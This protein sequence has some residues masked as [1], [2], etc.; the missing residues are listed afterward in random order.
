MSTA[1]SRHQ[2]DSQRLDE[3]CQKFFDH[4]DISNCTMSEIYS[5]ILSEDLPEGYLVNIVN[6][7]LHLYILESLSKGLQIRCSLTVHPDKFFTCC[8]NG[9]RI[10]NSQFSSICN[11]KIGKISELLNLA[12]ITK[13]ISSG[14][15]YL[16]RSAYIELA[17]A[18]LT[19]FLQ[20]CEQ[21][22]QYRQIK[23]IIEQLE[24]IFKNK[25]CRSYSAHLVVFAYLLYSH[26]TSAYEHL[27]VENI[28]SLPSI[29]TL[30]KVTR[31]VDASQGLDNSEYLKLRLSKLNEFERNVIL[32][33]DEI[34]VS[35][36][37][38]CTSGKIIGLTPDGSTASTLVCFMIKSLCSKYK[39]IVG[40]Y[41][42]SC[43]TAALQFAYFEDVLK[44]VVDCGFNVVAVSV[45]NAAVNRKFY[46]QFLCK[47]ELK[48]FVKNPHTGQPLFLIFDP[49]HN[50]K[51][52]Y[53]NFQSR[54]LFECPALPDTLPNGCTARFGDIVELYNHESG[55]SLRKAFNLSS[56]VISPKSIE[57]V[58]VKLACS[59]FSPS[60]RD[61]MAFYAA[62]ADKTHWAETADFLTMIIKLWDILNVKTKTK[63]FRKRNQAMDP[64]RSSLDWKLMFLRRFATFL[65]E[66]EESS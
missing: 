45:D 22:S 66:W 59:L 4:D 19:S 64:V 27:L 65:T 49:V 62:D 7:C 9:E 11:S 50:L 12:A 52:I 41:P 31:R 1:S 61:A 60:T 46:T 63:G 18:N 33:I 36:R 43:L 23:F 8:A 44:L 34:Y 26:S 53:N 24:L 55:M 38:E 48:V 57:K 58:S 37:V 54:K 35:K 3:A 21:D 56:T 6:D 29:R 16:D 14:D 32:I 30:Q 25:Y 20:N 42:V 39:D 15:T 40:M 2:K 47:G 51:N 17:I 13:N 10:L 28:I 5:R